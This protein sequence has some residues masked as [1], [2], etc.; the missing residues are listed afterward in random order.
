MSTK[1]TGVASSGISSMSGG[2]EARIS[3]DALRMDEGI[4]DQAS[5]ARYDEN[6][7]SSVESCA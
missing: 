5:V 6:S 4:V 1:D 7:S 2:I 3:Y